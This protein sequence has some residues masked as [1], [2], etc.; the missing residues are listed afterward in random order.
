MKK[1]YSIIFMIIIIILLVLWYNNNN[2]PGTV[3]NGTYYMEVDEV[4]IGVP[5]YIIY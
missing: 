2:V 3:K 4:E 1:R 5:P